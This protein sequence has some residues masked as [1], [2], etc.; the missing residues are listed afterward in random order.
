MELKFHFIYLFA[1]RRLSIVTVLLCALVTCTSADAG[2]FN[3][4]GGRL[5]LSQWNQDD[6]GLVALDGQWAFYWQQLLSPEDFGPAQTLKSADYIDVPG[7][8]N[9]YP[10]NTNKWPGD[11]FATYR[12]LLDNIP[13]KNHLIY[14]KIPE[15]PTAYRLW[16]NGDIVS[17]NGIVGKN[18]QEMKPVF[19][20]KIVSLN[21]DRPEIELVLQ[22][23]N[24]FHKDGGIWHSMEIGT[25]QDLASMRERP[26]F[27]DMLLFGGLFIMGLYHLGLYA[28]RRQERAPLYFGLFCLTVGIRSLLVGQRIFYGLVPGL[29]W[30]IQQKMEYLLLYLSAPAFFM[31]FYHL[32]PREVS[33][34][35]CSVITWC[36]GIFGVIVVA[37]P[38]KIY[39]HTGNLFQILVYAASAY[40]AVVMVKIIQQKREGSLL[41]AGG[42]VVLML[43]VINDTLYTHLIIQTR[44]MA[45]FGVF[46]FIFFQA[47]LLSKKFSG[48]FAKVEVISNE[49]AVKNQELVR[50]DK[51]KDEFLANTS[52]ELKTPLH[53]IIGLAES[54]VEGAAGSLASLQR[55]NLSIIASSGRRLFNLINDLLDFAKIRR[56]E[57]EL[58]LSPVDLRSIA[59]LV[60]AFT[61]PMIGDRQLK[62]INKI[63]ENLPPVAADENRLQQVMFNLVGNA[64]KFTHNGTIEIRAEK[65]KDAIT[66]T[67][68]DTGIGIAEKDREK[69]FSEFEQVYGSMDRSYGGTGLGLAISQRLIRLHGSE[70]TVESVP[71]KGSAF[72]FPLS[73]SKD[74]IREKKL[75]EVVYSRFL[76]GESAFSLHYE[77]DHQV[78]RAD[79]LQPERGTGQFGQS[80]LVVDDEPVNL[81][82][83]HNQLTPRGF[84]VFM[85]HDG[86]E[87]LEMIADEPPD[88]VLLD[89]MMPRMNG[90]DVCLK[91][92]ETHSLYSLPVIM[93]TA[94]NRLSD[95]VQGLESGANDYLPKPFYKEELLA[96]IDILLQAK[97]SVE[98]LKKNQL[99]KEEI[100]R[101]QKIEEKL[102][103]AQRRLAR[104][105]DSSEDA[106]IAVNMEGVISFFNQGAE[107]LFGFST[108]EVLNQTV[109]LLFSDSLIKDFTG[110]VSSMAEIS[111]PMSNADQSKQTVSVTGKKHDGT[112]F[113]AILYISGFMIGPDRMFTLIVR[114]RPKTSA[115]YAGD[116]HPAVCDPLESIEETPFKT[117]LAIEHA[118]NQIFDY[119]EVHQE[120]LVELRNMDP[121]LDSVEDQLPDDDA[122]QNNIHEILVGLMNVSL[123]HWEA[124]TGKTKVDLA[125]ESR[126]WKAYLDRGTWKTRTLDKYLALET[127]PKKPRWREVVRTANF[128]LSHCN[129]GADANDEIKSL[130]SQAEALLKQKNR[131]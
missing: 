46:M 96:R 74:E 10:K 106:I 34:R 8:W 130:I 31:F 95:L 11:G 71:E 117:V 52:H 85:A 127:L 129:P 121:A 38:A 102:R 91:I 37:A 28:L 99:L 15:M 50:L 43:T 22:V 12:L 49:L 125:E 60:I 39:G 111:T 128:V 97:A 56:N 3:A 4:A 107:H 82:L 58:Q 126:I 62:M 42:F 59:E 23:S 32:F 108:N 75:P 55:K 1:F 98:R 14:L 69:I 79:A 6:G 78:T 13:V 54:M 115:S 80:I 35:F 21:T 16:V 19:L 131:G 66:V 94:K 110:F 77:P 113:S 72:S 101:R 64:V 76:E 104:M 40:L 83:V 2:E 30:E 105:L 118:L 124:G 87:A 25:E 67:V 29:D 123:R 88:L 5:D 92:R 57:L 68:Q 86:F 17:E 53:G 100:Q 26:V 122:N 33:R 20:P 41:F 18:K 84:K 109:D 81:Q 93:L 73:I 47:F 61:T 70:I 119:S 114:N 63:P 27:F 90:F 48:A 116:N 112:T 9:R 45:H 24:F 44:P 103:V 36:C 7:L 89:I 51:L 65:K 120:E